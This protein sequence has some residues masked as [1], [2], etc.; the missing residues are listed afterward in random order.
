M[1]GTYQPDWLFSQLQTSGWAVHQGRSREQGPLCSRL[2]WGRPEAG[3]NFSLASISQKH[4]GS[5]SDKADRSAQSEEAEKWGPP[6]YQGQWWNLGCLGVC[7]LYFQSGL[8][9]SSQY[10]FLEN[11]LE[12]PVGPCR[13]NC[14]LKDPTVP[15]FTSWFQLLTARICYCLGPLFGCGNLMGPG[16]WSQCYVILPTLRCFAVSICIAGYHPFFTYQKAHLA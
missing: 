2:H 11:R 12:L 5:L 1:E 13:F 8:S 4:G 15:E 10:L 9:S 14:G 6:T 16:L 3:R 7:Q